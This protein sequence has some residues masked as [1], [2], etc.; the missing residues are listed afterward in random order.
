MKPTRWKAW[1]RERIAEREVQAG[2]GLVVVLR[3]RLLRRGQ[4][5]GRAGRRL[6][7]LGR[8]VVL[9]VV[10][11]LEADVE[12]A[13]AD[14][15]LREAEEELAAHV[16]QVALQAERF[17]QAEEVVGLVV[18]AQEGAGQAADAAVQADGVL[19][20]LLDLEQQIHGAGFGILVGF[21]VLID[22]ERLEVLE[23][24]EAQQ[25]VLP[26]LASCRPGLRR[27]SARGG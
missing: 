24:V 15:G 26:E 12:R 7:A 19:A 10:V 14:I 18:D 2:R 1:R 4:V 8:V 17:A 11:D 3:Q 16:A 25:A 9:L 13:V 5:E 23:L 22:L 21:G 20:L 27:A 6:V